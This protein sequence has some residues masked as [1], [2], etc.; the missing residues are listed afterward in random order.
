MYETG[1]YQVPQVIKEI[2]NDDRDVQVIK[3][4]SGLT[5]QELKDLGLVGMNTNQI[6]MQTNMEAF[7]NPEV[8]N[9]S[10]DFMNKYNVTYNK[11]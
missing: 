8:I 1:I 10:I 9:N 5:L 7:T 2:F 4:S 11:K 3:S 6:M